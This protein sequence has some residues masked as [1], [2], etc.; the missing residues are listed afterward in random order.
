SGAK[1]LSLAMQ[2]MVDYSGND[3]SGLLF[4]ILDN[5]QTNDNVFPVLE[6]VSGFVDQSA[7]E[8]T[9]SMEV[10]EGI[11]EDLIPNEYKPMYAMA[12]QDAPRYLNVLQGINSFFQH[13]DDLLGKDV[14]ATYLLIFQNYNEI[15]PTGGFIGS[16]GIATFDNGQMTDLRFDDIYNPDGQIIEQIDP[17][18][19]INLMTEEWG[20]RDANW[21]PDWP[22][23]ADNIVRMYEKEGGYTVDGVIAFTPEVVNRLLD[24]TGS[25]KMD[26]Y[27]VVLTG[28]NFAETVQRK[29]ELDYD[30]TENKPKKILADLVPILMERMQ[31]L[32]DDKKAEF[33]Q[34]CLDL[35]YE[36]HVMLFVYNDEVEKLID[37]MGWGGNI[38]QTPVAEDYL[39]MIHANIGG[40][41]SDLY[42][43]EA[44]RENV[45][46]MSDGSVVVDLEI[47]RRNIEDWTWPNYANY[48]YLRVYVPLGSELLAVDGFKNAEGIVIGEDQVIT[49]DPV[50]KEAGLANTKVYEESGKTV[51]ANWV[52][53]DP[54]DISVVKYKYLLPF[55]VKDDY[56]LYVQKQSGRREIDYM[57]KINTNGRSVTNV[58]FEP[59]E[60]N[61]DLVFKDDLKRDYELEMKF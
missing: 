42:I 53:T 45:E 3:F 41:K 52:V 20:M 15:R 39:S 54:W 19:P 4:N 5:K 22:T 59:T 14:P 33:W 7:S 25:V 9:Y 36:K 11:N 1:F 13:A 38:V 30:R 43:K 48:D 51:F 6:R 57:L 34:M 27:D 37:E 60:E 32:P 12:K 58:S 55:K 23:S 31:N 28:D 21:Y 24:M 61:G 50:F 16:Y 47:T 18:Y 8:L 29:I 10:F 40:R 44:V 26:E 2:E 35:M 49:Y 17:P 56:L 46:I